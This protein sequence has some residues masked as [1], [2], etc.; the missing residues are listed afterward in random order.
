MQ[1]DNE[2]QI[3]EIGYISIYEYCQ[4]LKSLADLLTNLD[5]LVTE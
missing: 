4:T 1:I 3:L 5:A 2:L